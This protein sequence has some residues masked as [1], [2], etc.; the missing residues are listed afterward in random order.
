MVTCDAYNDTWEPF[1]ILFEKF[2]PGQ[3]YDIISDSGGKKTWCESIIEYCGT[4][5][6][7]FLLLFDDF[8][9][10]GPVNVALIQRGFDIAR[11][12]NVGAVRLYPCPGA[13]EDVYGSIY[14]GRVTRYSEYRN[15]TMPTVWNPG[16]LSQIASRFQTPWEFE[17]K[18][19]PWASQHLPAE[20]WAFKREISP[21]PIEIIATA[22]TRGRW[23]KSALE[24]L[25]SHGI[26]VDRSMREIA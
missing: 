24:F 3:R 17:I 19:S 16:Y 5:K 2:W 11:R 8:F 12:D 10:S 14:Y 4:V 23:N 6:E 25:A 26:E 7:P 18:G 15:S 20:V 22:I 21:W 1:R 13:N 9:L